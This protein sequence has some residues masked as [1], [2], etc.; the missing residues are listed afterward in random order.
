M[1]ALQ[2][3]APPVREAA[4]QLYLQGYDLPAIAKQMKISLVAVR[5]MAEEYNWE[6]ALLKRKQA[7]ITELAAVI[8]EQERPVVQERGLRIASKLDSHIEKHLSLKKVK[9]RDLVNLAKAAQ[10][11]NAVAESALGT[12][13]AGGMNVFIQFN[14]QPRSVETLRQAGV[15]IDVPNTESSLTV[16]ALDGSPK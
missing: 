14:L 16:P 1:N 5:K 2:L 3:Y 11:S 13:K 8:Q 15:V 10:A 6:A 7:T 9:S 4:R 12:V